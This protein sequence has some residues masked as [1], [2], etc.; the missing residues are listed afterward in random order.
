MVLWKL[1]MASHHST[2]AML[3]HLKQKHPRAIYQDNNRS[4]TTQS[5]LFTFCP[6]PN[7]TVLTLKAFMLVVIHFLMLNIFLPA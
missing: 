3:E 2:T 7:V 6:Y 4:R 5:V 1:E